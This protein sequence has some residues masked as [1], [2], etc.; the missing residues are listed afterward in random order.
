MS[1]IRTVS[2]TFA[3]GVAA[4]V[5]LLAGLFWALPGSAAIARDDGA[6]GGIIFSSG[7]Q[8]GLKVRSGA[9]EQKR[10]VA[11]RLVMPLSLVSADFDGDGTPDVVC[12]YGSGKG[13]GVAEIRWGNPDAL[14]PNSP[15]ARARSGA[16]GGRAV[17]KGASTLFELPGEPDFLAAG[18]FNADGHQ[19][20]AVGSR[21]ASAF[22]VLPG[23]GR[24]G[25]NAPARVDLEGS[26][27]LLA[28]GDINRRDGLPELIA[29]VY[30]PDRASLLVYEGPS[31]A[32]GALPEEINLVH[33]AVEVVFG[34]LS[35]DIFG[36]M[37][38]LLSSGE[39]LVIYGRDRG[40]SREAA[41]SAE[42]ADPL[43]P[44]V[45]T[46]PF[47]HAT[48]LAAGDFLGRGHD[49]LASL[50]STGSLSLADPRDP[51]GAMIVK[52]GTTT[53]PV[54][55]VAKLISV[56]GSDA[57]QLV[58][59]KKGQSTASS[60]S[61]IAAGKSTVR[62]T[63]LNAAAVAIIPAR[64]RAD[65]S[66]DLVVLGSD[67]RDVL[68]VVSGKGATK[69]FVVTSGEYAE[70]TG[71]G[72]KRDGYCVTGAGSKAAGKCTFNAALWECPGATGKGTCIIRFNLP[73]SGGAIPVAAFRSVEA[74]PA[75][76][77]DGT[78]QPGT[79]LVRI[80][81]NTN[82]AIFK[83]GTT[84]KGLVMQFAEVGDRSRVEGCRFGV[85]DD[86]NRHDD[87]SGGL[88]IGSDCFVGGTT[89]AA[90]NLF[91]VHP[92]ASGVSLTIKGDRNIVRGN[93][94]GVNRAG[95]DPLPLK[96]AI[97]VVTPDGSVTGA[98]RNVIGGTTA[99]AR[100]VIWGAGTAEP[101][102][103][104]E[105]DA[106]TSGNTFQGNYLGTDP[107][108]AK[109]IGAGNRITGIRLGGRGNV[110]GGTA[111]A[112]RNIIAGTNLSSNVGYAIEVV[113]APAV[114]NKLVI[115]GNYIGLNA[116]GTAGM[117]NWRRGVVV[118][119]ESESITIGGAAAGAGNVIAGCSWAAI[120]I[121]GKNEQTGVQGTNKKNVIQGN[122]IGTDKTGKNAIP[123]LYGVI[124]MYSHDNLVG[125][126]T[127][128]AR[129]VIAGNSQDGIHIVGDTAYG[130]II[131]GNYVGVDATGKKKLPH[132]WYG[133]VLESANNIV[134]GTSAAARNV[135]STNGIGNVRIV[136]PA[137]T[138][139]K[140]QGNYIGPAANGTANP[141]G[142]WWGVVVEGGA[143]GNTIGGK[144]KGAG[145]VIA[146]NTYQGVVVMS[147]VVPYSVGN[148]ILGN[149]IHS[150]TKM[151][152]DLGAD[153]VTGNDYQDPDLGPNNF[154][155][156]P[157]LT[158]IETATGLNVHGTLNST[159]NTKF[160]LEFFA[161]CKLN[162]EKMTGGQTFMG[163]IDVVTSDYGD[164]IFS[165]RFVTPQCRM[166][167]AT[168]TDP[169]GNTSEFSLWVSP[170][171]SGQ[172]EEASRGDGE[173]E[174]TA[175]TEEE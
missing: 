163:A 42:A 99:G 63:A 51:S 92:A 2:R 134:G 29:G 15:E 83:A 154:Q 31:G 65:S 74:C 131:T 36:D 38:V 76:T 146:Y 111:A 20:L 93:W 127:T 86:G 166:I 112:A 75:A 175:G 50:S 109:A 40:L 169:N 115:Q 10:M 122:Y 18:D 81:S 168:A 91:S 55:S 159:P 79:R 5:M 98:S 52:T 12:G 48:A 155:N 104:V 161:N 174:V 100:N 119:P 120:N 167:T 39:V 172:I 140:V 171:K 137:A 25:F 1:V 41:S 110:I 17:F 162:A 108:G 45:A 102:N 9:A 66:A 44:T 54:G 95:T 130:N 11:S 82:S 157:V 59:F 141:G 72:S 103:L 33:D 147:K 118:S 47:P 28:A 151:G 73:V 160:R 22:F 8:V 117:G 116:A 84:L 149:S 113:G 49:I 107:T 132:P 96:T 142:G 129:N 14:F 123:N 58:I 156:T 150:T 67:S 125:G 126:T 57:D 46:I 138:G 53:G 133:V 6:S 105:F 121:K 106:G 37:A 144:E 26:L 173:E 60:V 70:D 143:S 21:G 148:A 158:S 164:A 77:Y 114:T 128:A 124:I 62:T 136:G 61:G 80:G 88:A 69:T 30:G 87:W 64:L 23:D 34:N 145:N 90:R 97:R 78:S 94:F 85:S 24:G 153:G 89:A 71:F 152:I 13:K 35:D 135:I 43:G 101:I 32:L 68:R 170:R 19:D 165:R 139:N 56:N 3:A 7:E 4:G 16:S 27:T